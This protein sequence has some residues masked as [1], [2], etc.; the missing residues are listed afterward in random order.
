M[1]LCNHCGEEIT[2]ETSFC[3]H[4]GKSQTSDAA[5]S[6]AT[7]STALQSVPGERRGAH[8]ET[9]ATET[10]RTA[11]APV[12]PFERRG[13]DDEGKT[14]RI[15]YGV[16]ALASV[17]IIAGVA[18]LV[19]R[20][21][22]QVAAPRLEN[23]IRPGT[24]EFEQIRDRLIVDFEPDE[25]A[26]VFE[27]ALGDTVITMTPTIRNFT[28]RSIDGLELHASALSLEKQVIK[29]KT[30]IPIPQRQATIEPNKTFTFDITLE[31]FTQGNKPASLKLD[32]TGVRF[33]Q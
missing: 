16:V 15:I 14:R 1:I 18:Y 8:D 12:S 20:P 24:P 32:L 23:A 22:A 13:D 3:P 26:N 30:V 2:E 10:S 5:V 27:R 33:K 25:N 28:G 9:A 4:C 29:E 7:P 19:T 11:S 17:L 31:G 6:P 21:R